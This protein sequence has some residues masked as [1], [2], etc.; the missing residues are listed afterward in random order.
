[1]KAFIFDLDGILVDTAKYHYITWKT[2]GT[3]F[4]FN[5][6]ETQNES[7]K[8]ISRTD[9]LDLML[10]QAGTETNLEQKEVLLR[11]KNDHYLK[12]IQEMDLTEILPGVLT[13]LDFTKKIKCLQRS[14][15]LV[16]MLN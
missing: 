8:G 12:L 1:M 11:Q 13:I 6:T 4:N 9:S 3:S 14:V 2:I 15:L 5:L 10:E 7:L 16:K